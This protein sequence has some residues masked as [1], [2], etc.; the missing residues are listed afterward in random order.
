MSQRLTQLE[1]IAIF[2]DL[3]EKYMRLLKPLFEPFACSAGATVL[4]QGTPADYLYLVISGAVEMNFKPYDGVPITIS[5]VE[6][7]GLF[8]WSAVV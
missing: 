4:R 2:K 6:K 1:N 3:D 7:D 8:G 5:H